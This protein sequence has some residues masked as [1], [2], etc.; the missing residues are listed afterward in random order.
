MEAAAGF[1]LE[2]SA[3]SSEGVS[4]WSIEGEEDGRHSDVSTGDTGPTAGD[5][6]TPSATNGTA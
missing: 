3:M 4:I 2:K 1:Y 5:T 6:A